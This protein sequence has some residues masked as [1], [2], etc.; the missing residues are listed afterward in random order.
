[1]AAKTPPKSV[2]AKKTPRKLTKKKEKD[3]SDDDKK[4]GKD[5]TGS[6]VKKKRKMKKVASIKTLKSKPRS[7]LTTDEEIV[8][9]QSVINNS[10]PKRTFVN[11]VKSLVRENFSEMRFKKQAMSILHEES[12]HMLYRIF[13]KL[14]F[15]Q[16]YRGRKGIQIEDL[17]LLNQLEK[18]IH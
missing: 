1:M 12:E 7:S 13:S 15:V 16:D 6:G 8:Y 10:I 17:K 11:L 9:Q 4:K 5:S 14:R 3:I 2:I 18:P